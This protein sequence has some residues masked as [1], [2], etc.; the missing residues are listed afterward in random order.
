MLQR[1]GQQPSSRE[2]QLESNGLLP[3]GHTNSEAGKVTLQLQVRPPASAWRTC[4]FTNL[5]TEGGKKTT[6]TGGEPT[7]SVDVSA[8]SC[9]RLPVLLPSNY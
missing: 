4:V 7:F 5:K 6:S 8:F 3:H 2:A 9:S 1:T